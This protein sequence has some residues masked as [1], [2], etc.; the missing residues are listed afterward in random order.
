MRLMRYPQPLV[1]GLLVAC[2]ILA[3]AWNAG[4]RTTTLPIRNSPVHT[5]ARVTTGV[6]AASQQQCVDACRKGIEAIEAF[7]RTIPDAR[8]RGACWAARFSMN[9][10]IGFCYWY[11]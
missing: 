9:A 7:C 5:A 4:A 6:S 10:C 2:G 8:A 11:Y 1:T 3:G